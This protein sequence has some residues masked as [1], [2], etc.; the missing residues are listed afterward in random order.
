MTGDLLGD[1]INKLTLINRQLGGD[2]VTTSGVEALLK[3]IPLSR[4]ITFI[5]LGFA[6]FLLR[7]RE[8]R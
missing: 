1:T 5:V 3:D 2:R 6:R 8:A 7:P 4:E